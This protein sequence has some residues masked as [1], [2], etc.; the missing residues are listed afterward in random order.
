MQN[1][2]L[3]LGV[4][5]HTRFSDPGVHT[6]GH[7]GRSEQRRMLELVRPRCFVPVH[8]TLH[9][10]LKHAELAREVGVPEVLVVENGTPVTCDGSRLRTEPEVSHGK[11]AIAMGGEDAPPSTLKERAELGRA[12]IVIVALGLGKDGRG[13]TPPSVRARGVPALDDR[14]LRA[15]EG[16]AARTLEDH[17]SGRGLPLEE[18][19]RRSVRRKVEEL[20]GVRPTVEVLGAGD[21]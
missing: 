19:V 7:A 3:R 10:L 1:D 20:T 5:L 21:R 16:E 6:S 8:G 4:A 9:H 11:V 15:L 12:G 14:A 2:L 13:V 17:G 18:R